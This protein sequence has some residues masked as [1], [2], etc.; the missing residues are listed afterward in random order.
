MSCGLHLNLTRLLH[1]TICGL[2]LYLTRL[3]HTPV[4]DQLWP[5]PDQPAAYTYLSEQ[6]ATYPYI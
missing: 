1:T 3:L 2:P 6:T 4:S 5:T